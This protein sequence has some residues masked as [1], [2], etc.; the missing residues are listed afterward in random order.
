MFT[1]EALEP[2]FHHN[3]NDHAGRH[4]ASIVHLAADI[5][6]SRILYPIAPNACLLLKD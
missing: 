4:Y 3:R 1:K 2:K 5:V 6:A